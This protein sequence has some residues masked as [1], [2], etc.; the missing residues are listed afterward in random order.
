MSLEHSLQTA[1]HAIQVEGAS[2]TPGFRQKLQSAFSDAANEAR[3][4]QAEVSDLKRRLEALE[5]KR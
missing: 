5:R 2:L 1:A 3:R 4:L